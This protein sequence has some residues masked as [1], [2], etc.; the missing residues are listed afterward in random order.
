MFGNTLHALR[1][2]AGEVRVATVGDMTTCLPQPPL[3]SARFMPKQTT[4][5]KM[6]EILYR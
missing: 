6:Q 4:K 1:K 2:I 5:V 3:D